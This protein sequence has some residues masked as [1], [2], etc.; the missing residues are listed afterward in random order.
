MWLGQGRKEKKKILS[1]KRNGYQ[2]GSIFHQYYTPLGIPPKELTL[3][4]RWILDSPKLANH[5]NG[6]NVQNALKD[7]VDCQISH[8]PC[9]RAGIC[10]PNSQSPDAELLTR[11][12][13]LSARSCLPYD[14]PN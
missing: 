12:S 13:F 8:L 11:K 2:T 10:T 4:G 14:E 6:L 3:W 9:G 1:V 5:I 7:W